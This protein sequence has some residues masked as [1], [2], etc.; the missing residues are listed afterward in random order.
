MVINK[1]MYKLKEGKKQVWRH[2]EIHFILINK[3]PEKLK[4][5]KTN[6]IIRGSHGNPHLFGNGKIYF[7]SIPPFIIGYFLAKDTILLHAEHG[8]GKGN[9]KTAK[10]PNGIYEIRRAAEYTPEGLKPVID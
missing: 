4:E 2:G 6:T 8:E 7:K 9:I 1:N 3:L 10:L 5:T